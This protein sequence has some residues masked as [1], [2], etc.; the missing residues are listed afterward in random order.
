MKKSAYKRIAQYVLIAGVLFSSCRKDNPVPQADLSI[1][2]AIDNISPNVGTNVTV[3]ITATNNGPSD[4]T[5]V[6]VN[7]ALPSG[8]TLVS[9]TK[10]SGA[11]TSPTWTIGKLAN[12][13]TAT[14]TVVAKVNGSGLYDNKAIISGMESDPKPANNTSAQI[15]IKAVIPQANEVNTFI[16][17]ALHDVYLWNSLVPNLSASKFSITD[18]LNVFLNTYSDPQTLFT[19]LLYQYNKIDK[20]SFLVDNSKTI[21]DWISGTS[22]TMGFDFMLGT[23]GNSDNLFGFVR[24]VIKGSPAEAAGMKRGDIF[25]K[26]NDQ[27]LTVS[28]YQNLL[29]NTETYKLGFATIENNFIS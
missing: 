28:N 1:T 16:W 4:A 10:T 29:I 14:L 20:W 12:T 6:T 17:S 27:Q 18:S 23:I 2:K 11:W 3:T 7:Y 13:G 26:V 8:Y 24:Y 9:A 25:M 21:D 15:T 19:D 22:K 5:G